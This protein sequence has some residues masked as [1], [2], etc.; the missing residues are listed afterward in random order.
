[1]KNGSTLFLRLTVIGLGLIAVG[2]AFL[3]LPAIYTGWTKEYPDAAYL[4]LPA[5]VVLSATVIPF[6]IAL[7]QTWKLLGYVDKNDAFSLRS[8][9]ALRNIK[10]CAL[11]F[12]A[13]Y[14]L[15]LPIVYY[16][17]QQ[18]D[19]PGLMVIGLAMTCAPVVIAVFAAVLQKLLH[20]AITI[21]NEND[22]TV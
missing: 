4:Q 15:F 12:S 3:I 16:V 6:F 20:S 2:L 11:A 1:M 13:L 21:K 17:T 9:V 10:Y 14:A 7:Y 19:A 18:E 5:F 8:V 22:L